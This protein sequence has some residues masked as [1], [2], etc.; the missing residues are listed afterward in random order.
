MKQ[1]EGASPKEFPSF[2]ARLRTDI[3]RNY[4]LY[5]LLVPVLA[6]YLIFCYKPMYGALIAF[7]EYRPALGILNSPWVGFQHFKALFK[8]PDFLIILRNTLVIS[9]S[10]LLIVFPS[11]IILALLFNE[12]K[13]KKLKTISQTLAYL[14][15]FISAVVVCG[16]VK[17]FISRGGFILH[18]VTALGGPKTSLLN[19]PEYFVPIYI[20]TELWQTVGW[21]SIIYLAAL[22]GIDEGLYEAAKIDGANKW[23][24]VWHVTIPGIMP[25]IIVMLIL[26]VGGLLSVGYEKIILLYNPNIYETADVINSY[27]YR[28]GLTKQSWSYSSAVGLLNSTVNFLLVIVTN[29]ISRKYTETSLW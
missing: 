21:S 19:F 11:A 29:T 8:N 27:V 2:G 23:K 5:L 12:L 1:K 4:K 15:H 6:Y 24:Q 25:T 3:K 26:A 20:G 14:P 7:Q 28:V 22:S 9:I 10:S 17:G 16:M 18:L 13:L